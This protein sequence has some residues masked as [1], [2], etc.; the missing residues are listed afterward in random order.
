M[1][2][3]AKHSTTMAKPDAS[4]RLATAF[5]VQKRAVVNELEKIA[6]CYRE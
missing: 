1:V 6:G 4:C 2:I 5:S 3:A